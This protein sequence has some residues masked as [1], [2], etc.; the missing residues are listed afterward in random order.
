MRLLTKI[1]QVLFYGN[2]FLGISAVALCVE[3]NLLNNISLN[4]FPFYL[5]IFL[6]TCIYYTRIYVRSVGT[7]NYDDRTI[8]YRKNFSTIKSILKYVIVVAFIFLLFLL[9]KNLHQFLLLPPSQF[10]LIIAFP[11]I[12]AWYTF[13]PAF[14]RIRNIRQVGW[15]KPFIVGLTWAGWVTFYPVIIWN[16]ETGLNPSLSFLS[17]FLL[18]LQNLLFFS[19]NAIIFDIKDL[20]TDSFNR[21]KTYPVIF[22]IKKTFRF[23]VIPVTFLNLIVFFLFQSQNN[24]SLP[25][26][27]V[28]L[29]PYA[30]LVFVIAKYRR[31]R[32]VLY[33][34]AIVDGLVF[35]KAICGIAS[36]IFLK[37]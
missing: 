19:I 1:I 16:L 32:N 11:L 17:L 35:L 18:W 6:C 5:L 31:G 8:W 33:Y 21:L 37:K 7:K 23:I 12:A 4:V 24:F 29:I 28:Q 26:V 2:I 30:L 36:I 22:G 9:V 20:R 13:A 3:T 27:A 10:I 25:Q 15:I 14:L 34:L